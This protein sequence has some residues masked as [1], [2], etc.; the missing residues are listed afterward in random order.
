MM[1]VWTGMFA[2]G[3]ALLAGP[4]YA[5]DWR[6]APHIRTLYDA[7]KKEG[8]VM[9]WASLARDVEWMP[10]EFASAFPGIDMKF[11]GDQDLATKA[12]AEA[13][14][15]R[16]EVDV[17]QSSLGGTIPVVQRDLLAK[18]DWAEFGVQPG[19]IAFDGRVALTHNLVYVVSY[20]VNLVKP[21]DLPK[22]WA[23]LLEPRFKGKIASTSF[24]LPRLVGFLGLEWG[25]EK[26]LQFAR[27]LVG[28]QEALVSRTP[29]QTFLTSGERWYGA[30]D[31]ESGVRFIKSQG[32]PIDFVIPEP[33]AAVQFLVAVMAKA[34]HP[35]A[36]R[37][38]V[39]WINSS[40]GRALRDKYVFEAD[41]RPGSDHP[42]AKQLRDAGAKVLFE[43]EANMAAREALYNKAAPIVSGQVK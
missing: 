27:D 4:T 19:N 34:P 3:L 36:A 5:A 41:Y 31:F 1:R 10:K 16:H 29:T 7:A 32:A 37:L 21:A 40:D 13:R 26:A 2:L 24:L 23:D 28:K 25:D 43:S 17:F 38:L 15:G 20:N 14:A 22:N 9:L 42:M 8:A 30:S 33:V 6:D 11:L 12:I 35:N 39:A 18:I